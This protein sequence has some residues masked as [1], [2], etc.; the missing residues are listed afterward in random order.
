MI[1]CEVCLGTPQDLP[2]GCVCQLSDRP[3]TYQGMVDGL[4]KIIYEYNEYICEK[5]LNNDFRNWKDEK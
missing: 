2:N 4:R 1:F 3:R 5:G